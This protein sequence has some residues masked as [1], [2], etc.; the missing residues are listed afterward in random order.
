M[1]RWKQK[2]NQFK[3][4]KYEVL[5]RGRVSKS[6]AL[7]MVDGDAGADPPCAGASPA[8][9]PSCAAEILFFLRTDPSER[10]DAPGGAE[11]SLFER[12][13]S[14]LRRYRGHFPVPHS[15]KIYTKKSKQTFPLVSLDLVYLSRSL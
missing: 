12:K 4:P 1:S 14:R 8:G 7:S 15:C 13:S 9:T 10:S 2:S 5:D 6:S 11:A 3:S